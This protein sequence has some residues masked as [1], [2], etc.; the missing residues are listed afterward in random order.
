MDS[1]IALLQPLGL[2]QYEARAF[3]TLVQRGQSTAYQV[4]KDSGIPRARIYD[5][6]DDLTRQG[7]VM[8]SPTPDDTKRYQAVPVAACL[9]QWRR[10]W[11]TRLDA[12]E[13]ELHALTAVRPTAPMTL[14]T[15]QGADNITAFC[16]MLVQRAQRYVMLSVWEAFYATLVP[17]LQTALARGIRVKGLVMNVTPPV[18]GDL[19]SHR[20]NPYM[21]S[22]IKDRWFI[23]SVDG[24]ELCYG[25][26][27]EHDG[28]AFY[29]NDSVHLYL[30]EDYI[31]HDVLVNTLVAQGDPAAL[32]AWILPAQAAFFERESAATRGED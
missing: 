2:T 14:A 22:I 26:T 28:P 5:V 18:L 27:P 16:R 19:A 4:S 17:D 29:T 8:L 11:Q 20:I 13:A 30:F 21:A 7:L 9:D 15:L 10:R 24:R 23:L 25:H 31:W 6:L 3:A 12:V 32:D 1:L